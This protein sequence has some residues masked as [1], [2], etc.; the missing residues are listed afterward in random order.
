LVTQY[1]SK[2]LPRGVLR[3]GSLRKHRTTGIKEGDE[4]SSLEI[5][6]T[7]H[8]LRHKLSLG[9]DKCW[10]EIAIRGD[11]ELEALLLGPEGLERVK[12]RGMKERKRHQIKEPT[13]FNLSRGAGTCN[14]L[15]S[16]NGNW[17]RVRMLG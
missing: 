5:T 13:K 15:R 11:M 10:W 1:R 6:V 17:K 14:R 7:T 4:T 2:F 12:S 9:G 8:V 3:L 16:T